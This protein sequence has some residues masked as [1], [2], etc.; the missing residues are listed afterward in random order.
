L[1]DIKF[2]GKSNGTS[3]LH[4]SINF[5]GGATATFLDGQIAMTFGGYISGQVTTRQEKFTIHI[6]R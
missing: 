3:H 2:I 4:I 1:K 5:S 6:I